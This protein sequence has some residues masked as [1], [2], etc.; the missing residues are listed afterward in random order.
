MLPYVPQIQGEFS[1]SRLENANLDVLETL[2]I[3]RTQAL[4]PIPSVRMLFCLLLRYC[5]DFTRHPQPQDRESELYSATVRLLIPTLR[6]Y[7]LKNQEFSV[8]SVLGSTRSNYSETLDE[9]ILDQGND[10]GIC[11]LD[12]K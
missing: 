8:V 12:W 7:C 1:H 2:Q 5:D 3:P 9:L 6:P 10:N 4:T 11:C